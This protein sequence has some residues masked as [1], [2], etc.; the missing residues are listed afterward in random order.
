MLN[1]SVEWHL[2]KESPYMIK[3]LKIDHSKR[4]E[5]WDDKEYIR[6]FLD[7]ARKR[8]RY[9]TAYLLALETGKRLGEIVGLSKKDVD[10]DRGR[11]HVWRQWRD[12]QM[13]YGPPKHGIARWVDF[14]PQ[15]HLA[16][17]LADTVR[18]SPHAEAIFTTVTNRRVGNRKL[19]SDYFQHLVRKAGVPRICFHSLRHTFASWYMVEVGDIWALMSILG[20]QSVVTTHRYA[21]H[22]TR[23]QHKP[24]ELAERSNAHGLPTKL[25][26]AER[27]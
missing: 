10:F 11:I 3:A 13:K 6:R 8:S 9:Y 26:S 24:L 2:M 12:K 15:G 19:A 21:H 4:L 27:S 1:K 23:H 22:S 5:W 16:E 7:E 20:H 25:L 14:N 17:V 18:H